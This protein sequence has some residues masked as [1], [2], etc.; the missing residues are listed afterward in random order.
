MKRKF[1]V[2]ILFMCIVTILLGQ[3][4][5]N[6]TEVISTPSTGKVIVLDAGHGI[7]DEGA[8]G[9]RGTT[10]QKI[11][12]EIVLKIQ[13]LLEQN[14]SIVVITRSD[15]KAIYNDEKA[16]IKQKKISDIYNR[17]D[18]TNSSNADLL[19]SIHLN[20]FTDPKYSGWQTFYKTGSIKSKKIAEDIQEYINKNMNKENN[21]IPR[22]IKDIYLID[23]SE[24]PS[25]VVECGFI[26]NNEE[27]IL[28]KEN[29]YQ[30]KI[31]WGIFMGIQEY[32]RSESNE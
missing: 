29:E 21:R 3:K 14:G 25:V 26:S 6:V 16:S 17:V 22:V 9:F 15:E 31:A 13:K 5:N 10:E 4:N 30:N 18:I 24:I 2:C 27:S 19:V 23:N 7:P 11:N 12:L 20:K 32:F 1:I 28:L 8:V